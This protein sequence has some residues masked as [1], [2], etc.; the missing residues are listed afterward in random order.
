MTK[1][2]INGVMTVVLVLFS[3]VKGLLPIIT[4]FDYFIDSIVLF[5]VVVVAYY[6]LS[7]MFPVIFGTI[8][9]VLWI[10]GAVICV[11]NYNLWYNIVYFLFFVLTAY[12]FVNALRQR[13]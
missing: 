9:L 6:I 11:M 3:I 13:D 2:F 4:V 7:E 5:G 8:G 12:Q 10:D 1:S